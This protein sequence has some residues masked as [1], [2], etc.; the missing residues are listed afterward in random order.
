MELHFSEAQASRV[1]KQR[2]GLALACAALAILAL[3]T[4]I[5]AASRDR[6]VVLQP[7]LGRAMTVSSAALDRDY[8]EL[9]TRDTAVLM[10][11]RT[12]QSLDYWMQAVLKI[13]HPSAYGKLKGELI[14]IAA[15]QRG[16]AI[17][18]Y[19]TMEGLSVDPAHLSSSVTGVLHTMVGREEVSTVHRTFQFQWIYTGVELRLVGFGALEPPSNDTTQAA[20]SS[21][22]GARP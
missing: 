20:A 2:N 12:P 4:G 17:A 3:G 21:A 10:L 18:Q 11:N 13:V 15:D 8:L 9:V 7:I 14:K 19:F 1:L 16:T 6:Q 5:A 22:P